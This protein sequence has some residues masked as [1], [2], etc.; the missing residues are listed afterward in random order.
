MLVKELDMYDV[1]VIMQHNSIHVEC[2]T[3]VFKHFLQFKC[4]NKK[5]DL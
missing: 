2:E 4:Y 1:H 3:F 5:S